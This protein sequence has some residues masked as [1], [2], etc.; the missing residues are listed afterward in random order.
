MGDGFIVDIF[1]VYIIKFFFGYGD[2][3][4][5]NKKNILLEIEILV[6]FVIYE[7]KE[8]VNYGIFGI[9]LLFTIIFINFL[10]FFYLDRCLF[11]FLKGIK[12]IFLMF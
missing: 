3:L 7:F 2:V 12:V 6:I 5:I 1:L 10:Y 9:F 11:S 8:L 4:W